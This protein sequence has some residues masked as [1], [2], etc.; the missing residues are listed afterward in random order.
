MSCYSKSF[1]THCVNVYS[2]VEPM[3]MACDVDGDGMV[4]GSDI[5]KIELNLCPET[6]PVDWR[7]LLAVAGTLVIGGIVIYYAT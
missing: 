1:Y 3:D 4:S 2:G 5:G 7:I 6:K